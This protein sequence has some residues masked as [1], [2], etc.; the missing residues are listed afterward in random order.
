MTDYIVATVKPWNLGAFRRHAPRL[1][2]RW[3]LIEDRESLTLERINALTPQYVFFPHWSWRVPTDILAATECVCFHMTD[4][5]YGRGGSPLQNLIAAGHDSTVVTALRM[6]DELD[7]GPIYMKRPLELAGRAQD[8]YERLADLVYEMV[9]EIVARKPAPEPQQGEPTVFKRRTPEQS[10]LPESG[11]LDTLYDHIRMLDAETYPLA[12]LDH[13]NFRLEF[14]RAEL[15][16][17][18]LT[19]RVTL[20]KRE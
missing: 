20:R 17:D 18:A 4:L 6:V 16:G 14:T 12:F 8:I 10:R 1:P 15:L 5:P 2:G 9:A 11:A 13:G 19:A 7:A 3:H